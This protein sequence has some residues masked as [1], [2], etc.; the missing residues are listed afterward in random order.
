MK[1]EKKSKKLE[2][3]KIT[4]SSLSKNQLSK[5]KG[6]ESRRCSVACKDNT[7]HAGAC[8]YTVP[9]YHPCYA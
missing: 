1:K 3:K 2:L 6:G 8:N 5:A 4:I 7:V 9:G